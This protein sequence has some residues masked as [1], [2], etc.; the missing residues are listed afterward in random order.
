MPSPF[1]GM[2]PYLEH[3][4]LWSTFQQYF[5]GTLADILGEVLPRRFQAQIKE[6]VFLQG[7]PNG[8][9]AN[10]AP[11]VSCLLPSGPSSIASPN[12]L[13]SGASPVWHIP[14]AAEEL[15]E[16]YLE[17]VVAGEPRQLLTVI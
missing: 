1:P 2:D 6:R 12:H 15:R 17:I 11:P 4:L 5:I 7:N 13:P 16:N 10:Q 14:T 8:E 9:L 3:P